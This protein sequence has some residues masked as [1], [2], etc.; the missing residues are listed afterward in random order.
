M[1]TCCDLRTGLDSVS[2]GPD[3]GGRGI[4]SGV[5]SAEKK[6]RRKQLRYVREQMNIIAFKE[7]G[8]RNGRWLKSDE[9]RRPTVTGKGRPASPR[10]HPE[11]DHRLNSLNS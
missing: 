11:V 1:S 10:L 4:A 3:N 6:L 8:R 2:E 9:N 5:P 7:V